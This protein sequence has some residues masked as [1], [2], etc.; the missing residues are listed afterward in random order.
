M[1]T[2]LLP[3]TTGS[4]LTCF[5]STI[6]PA[7]STVAC[8]ETLI[9]GQDITSRTF[10]SRAL[11]PFTTI[12][13]RKS[14]SVIMPATEP[15]STTTS[16]DKLSSAITVAAI[17]IVWSGPTTATS[18][19]IRSLT[20]SQTWLEVIRRFDEISCILFF[21]SSLIFSS[22]AIFY[23]CICVTVFFVGTPNV[24]GNNMIL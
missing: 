2:S 9:T 22:L 4:R 18:V 3:S 12:F 17:A 20:C 14:F 11:L 15:L 5:S 16:D 6:L 24:Y 1:P 10:V 19:F 7:S 21:I 13:S 8:G 23:S